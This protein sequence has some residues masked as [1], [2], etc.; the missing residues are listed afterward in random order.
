[1]E[2]R[3]FPF[4]RQALEFIIRAPASMPRNTLVLVPKA[5]VDPVIYN[6]Q[7]KSARQDPD[8]KDVIGGWRVVHI[9]YFEWNQQRSWKA[10]K[11][12]LR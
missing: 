3:R 1:M 6:Q 12:Y 4:D 8:G 9:P 10:K 11:A 2:F 7:N 5:K